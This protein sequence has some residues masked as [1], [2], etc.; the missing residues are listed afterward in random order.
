MKGATSGNCNE[1]S[2]SS[3]NLLDASDIILLI[4]IIGIFKGNFVSFSLVIE[5]IWMLSLI[6]L[7]ERCYSDAFTFV[8]RRKASVWGINR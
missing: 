3:A 7:E 4:V 8:L 1:Y 6:F 2:E 5:F